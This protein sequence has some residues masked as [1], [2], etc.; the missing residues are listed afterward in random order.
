MKHIPVLHSEVLDLLNPQKGET[1]IDVTL[2]LGGHAKA[3]LEAIGKSGKLFGVDADEKNLEEAAKALNVEKGAKVELIHGN[4]KEYVRDA[5]TP[6][7]AAATDSAQHDVLL[8][9]CDILFADLGLSSPHI[10]DPARGFT[11]REDSPL[12]CRYDQSQGVSASALLMQ[13]SEEELI[14]IFKEFGELKVAH[15]LVRAIVEA[16]DKKS[17]SQTSDLVLIVDEVFTFKAKKLLPQIFQALRI[18]VN[19]E[20]GALESLLEYGPTLLNDGGRMGVI[21]YHSLEDRL[22]KQRFGSLSAGT[23]ASYQLL[24]K[25]A[26]QPTLEEI[27]QNPRARSARFRCIKK[28]S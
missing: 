24:T 14:R 18:A 27:E 11:Y 5:S 4:F 22:V 23:R 6:S 28:V 16:R 10:D 1:V 20:I 2:G 21:S 3:F 12:D 13:S 19:D 7:S 26:V 17:L 8:P 15:P 25:K 9:T